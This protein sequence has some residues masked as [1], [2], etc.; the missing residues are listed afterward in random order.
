VA[1]DCQ[2]CQHALQDSGAQ[3]RLVGALAWLHRHLQPTRTLAQCPIDVVDGGKALRVRM[4]AQ[5]N[6]L[7]WSVALG[8]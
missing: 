5:R 6:G 4:C 3:Q 2:T 8:D 7:E 1:G